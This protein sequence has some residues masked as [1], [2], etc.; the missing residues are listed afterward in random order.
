MD[1]DHFGALHLVLN[2]GALFMTF[3]LHLMIVINDSNG[4]EIRLK[5]TQKCIAPT[6]PLPLP[7][8]LVPILLYQI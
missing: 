8:F 5:I 3:R 1:N 2:V 7:F 6:L 4:K